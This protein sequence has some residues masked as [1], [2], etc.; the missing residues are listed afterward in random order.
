M[1]DRFMERIAERTAEKVKSLT[2]DAYAAGYEAGY[3]AMVFKDREDQNRRLE[4]MYR[5]GKERGREEVQ[6]EIGEI[7]SS[8][9]EKL[10]EMAEAEAEARRRAAEK[11][12]PVITM[13][14]GTA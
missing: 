12:H 13:E 4:D 2:E 5:K 3:T 8:F 9:F 14:G 10:T 6:A 11:P 1:F 7:D